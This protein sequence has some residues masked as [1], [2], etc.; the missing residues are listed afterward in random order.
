MYTSGRT[1]GTVLERLT[2]K[3]QIRTTKVLKN[4]KIIFGK[5]FLNPQSGKNDFSSPDLSGLPHLQPVT[6]QVIYNPPW[7]AARGKITAWYLQVRAAKPED[8]VDSKAT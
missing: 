3:V 4:A 2:Q 6:V 8:S 7:D 5:R 1:I